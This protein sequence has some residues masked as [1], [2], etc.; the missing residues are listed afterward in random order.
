MRQVYAIVHEKCI[1]WKCV[2]ANGIVRIANLKFKLWKIKNYEEYISIGDPRKISGATPQPS[3]DLEI[4]VCG[5]YTTAC[6]SNQLKVL[7]DNGYRTSIYNPACLDGSGFSELGLFGRMRWRV[8][9]Y[10][11]E[12]RRMHRKRARYA[13]YVKRRNDG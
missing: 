1:D 13:E 11:F 3:G 8:L 4:L 5:A 6:V 10:F 9:D 2:K 7:K 12:L